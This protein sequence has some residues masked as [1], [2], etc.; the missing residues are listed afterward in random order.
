MTTLTDNAVAA[1]KTALY[2]ACESRKALHHGPGRR[3]RFKLPNGHEGDAGHRDSGVKVFVDVGS[4]PRI[5]RVTIDFVT[6]SESS[7]LIFD[8]PNVWG[9]CA[10]GK[11]F[12]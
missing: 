2:R 12:G 9:T 7:G 6:V 3:L 10:C 11:S 1:A 4:P 5:A 8:N